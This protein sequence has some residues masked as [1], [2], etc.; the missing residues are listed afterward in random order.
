MNMTVG[1]TINPHKSHELNVEFNV[2]APSKRIQ[3][4]FGGGGG[5]KPCLWLDHQKWCPTKRSYKSM[6]KVVRDLRVS[7]TL[8]QLGAKYIPN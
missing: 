1:D 5:I 4:T 7:W 3:Y 6:G 2:Y 8:V